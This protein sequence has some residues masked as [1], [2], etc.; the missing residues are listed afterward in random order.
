MWRA[1]WHEGITGPG[2]GKCERRVHARNEFQLGGR[3][4][5]GSVG[6]LGQMCEEE[7]THGAPHVAI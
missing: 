3:G 2:A 1:I 4:E 5:G 6:W 7:P